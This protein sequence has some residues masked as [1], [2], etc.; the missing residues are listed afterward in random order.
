MLRRNS[1]T[2]I[3]LR[4]SLCARV[5]Y[6]GDGNHGRQRQAR[7]E[8]TR[9]RNTKNYA[10]SGIMGQSYDKELVTNHVPGIY[11]LHLTDQRHRFVI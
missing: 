10:G 7:Q 2:I 5:L 1:G 6:S 11:R 3:S 4:S 8:S 9:K